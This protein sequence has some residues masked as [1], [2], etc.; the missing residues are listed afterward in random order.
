MFLN[1]RVVWVVRQGRVVGLDQ[2]GIT[3]PGQRAV[4]VEQTDKVGQPERRD[5]PAQRVKR[6]L[7][8]RPYVSGRPA[9]TDA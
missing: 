3:D 5:R 6:V 2:V 1:H 9:Q 4:E 8:E 7:Q